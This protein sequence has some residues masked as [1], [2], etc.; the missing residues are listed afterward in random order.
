MEVRK[1]RKAVEGNSR[2]E[3]AGTGRGEKWALAPGSPHG[4]SKFP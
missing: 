2:E 4:E 3:A 1:S